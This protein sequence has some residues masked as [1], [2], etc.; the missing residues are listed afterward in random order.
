LSFASQEAVQR[1]ARF[2]RDK[3]D[4]PAITAGKDILT[5]ADLYAR[6]SRLAAG[7]RHHGVGEQGWVLGIAAPGTHL[8]ELEIAAWMR[9]ACPVILPF[10]RPYEW[11]RAEAA[12]FG[13]MLVISNAR[14]DW[15]ADTL[16]VSTPAS[17]M[18]ESEPDRSLSNN[19][20]TPWAYARY[21]SGTTAPPRPTATSHRAIEVVLDGLNEAIF[22][23]VPS[24]R[25]IGVF[26]AHEFDTTVKQLGQVL[27]GRSVISC[28][29]MVRLVPTKLGRWIEVN[30]V[31]VIDMPPSILKIL[32]RQGRLGELD[33]ATI[34]SGGEALDVQTWDDL[35]S[36]RTSRA[37]SAYGVTECAAD[38]FL[39]HVQVDA[40]PNLGRA[41]P[42]VHWRIDGD[43][44]GEL[45]LGGVVVGTPL[46]ASFQDQ[47]FDEG[48]LRWYRTGDRCDA[49]SGALRFMARQGSRVKIAGRWVDTESVRSRILGMDAVVDAVVF[50]M[51]DGSSNGRLVALV[52]VD[53]PDE[54]LRVSLLNATPE[55]LQVAFVSSLPLTSRGKPDLER[56]RQHFE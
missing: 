51:L 25:S 35:G 18:S 22:N 5:F 45:L 21:S 53:R 20:S 48:P 26:G 1:L 41:L 11:Y 34:I 32:S 37:Y 49:S 52:A 56:A 30:N 42:G 54:S 2:A 6:A 19:L 55:L 13:E 47:F 3:S 17:M 9:G 29:Q 27:S 15:S 4:V 46:D 28:P 23:D 50:P 14:L 33:G 8:L 38:S 40:E 39:A 7:M 10:G 43:E 36:S 24:D 31:A 16:A 12:R 44:S